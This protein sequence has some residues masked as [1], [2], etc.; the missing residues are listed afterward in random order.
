AEGGD[1]VADALLGPGRGGADGLAQLL[2]RGALVFWK[3]REVAVDR[4]CLALRT[5]APRR[6]A[7]AS[8]LRRTLAS[9]GHLTRT[10]ATRLVLRVGSA[11]VSPLRWRS[12]NATLYSVIMSWNR[13]FRSVQARCPAPSN[14]T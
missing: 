3:A 6:R 9:L 7:L 13:G 1:A 10:A 14:S 12:K 8:L 5:L 11:A 4:L 2:E